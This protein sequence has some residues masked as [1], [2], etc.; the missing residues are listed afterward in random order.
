MGRK[1]NLLILIAYSWL[2]SFILL[3]L[4]LSLFYVTQNYT[5][6]CVL[7]IICIHVTGLV[8]KSMHVWEN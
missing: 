4:Y 3:F 5:V 2:D 6:V 8:Y 1:N 7:F